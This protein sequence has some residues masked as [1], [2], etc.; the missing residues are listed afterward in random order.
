M[1]A[2][3]VWAAAIVLFLTTVVSA[4]GTALVSRKEAV[5]RA[6][7]NTEK[8]TGRQVRVRNATYELSA[9]DGRSRT[10][11]RPIA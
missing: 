6:A 10:G 3:A 11:C 5:T 4:L 2:A 9:F 7:L 1:G 8:K